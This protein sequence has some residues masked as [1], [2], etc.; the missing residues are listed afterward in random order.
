MGLLAFLFA[1]GA[2]LSRGRHE[3][4]DIAA[5]VLAPTTSDAATITA[6]APRRTTDLARTAPVLGAVLAI[7]L[8]TTARRRSDSHDPPWRAQLDLAPV[9]LRR[10]PPAPST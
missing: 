10:G 3:A 6:V 9:P 7:A 4:K 8:L 2:A 5:A 1:P